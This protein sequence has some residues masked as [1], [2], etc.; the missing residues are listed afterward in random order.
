M[1]RAASSTSASGEDVQPLKWRLV[2][3]FS[4]FK[5]ALMTKKAPIYPPS[6]LNTAKDDLDDAIPSDYVSRKRQNSVLGSLKNASQ[7]VP[8]G[9]LSG[10]G[11]VSGYE[12]V[13]NWLRNEQQAMNGE[14]IQNT[15]DGSVIIKEVSPSIY[16][17]KN[18]VLPMNPMEMDD[19]IAGPLP[20]PQEQDYPLIYCDEDGNPVRPP[21]INFD[22]RERYHMLKLKKSVAATEQLRNS[23][24]YMV[25]PDETIS[26]TRPNNKVDCST[27]THNREYLNKALHFTALKK[28]LALRNRK[29]RGKDLGRRMFS[30]SFSYDPIEAK[31]PEDD[32][33]KLKGYLGGLSQPTFNEITPAPKNPSLPDQEIEPVIKLKNSLSDRTGFQDALRSGKAASVLASSNQANK[34]FDLSNIIQLKESTL[35]A[36]KPSAGPS[37]GF[38]FDLNKESLAPLLDKKTAGI[39]V[40][41]TTTS[42]I[43][44]GTEPL[45]SSDNTQSGSKVS[46]NA[47]NIGSQ[48][49]VTFISLT[50]PDED[51]EARVTKKSRSKSETTSQPFVFGNSTKSVDSNSSTVFP[52]SSL[53]KTSTSLLGTDSSAS[54]PI[55]FGSADQSSKE[56]SD[57]HTLAQPSNKAPREIEPPKFSFGAST[58]Q[59]EEKSAGKFSFGNKSSESIAKQEVPNISFGTIPVAKE[60][61]TKSPTPLFG[62]SVN[63]LETINTKS[64]PKPAFSLSNDKATESTSI[65]SGFGQ[66]NSPNGT[67]DKEKSSSL[68]FKGTE[69]TTSEDSNKVEKSTCL[70]EHNRIA[71]KG[72]SSITSAPPVS[73]TISFGDSSSP[74]FSSTNATEKSRSTPRFEPTTDDKQKSSGNASIFGPSKGTEQKETPS[75]GASDSK[76]QFLFGQATKLGQKTESLS[77]GGFKPKVTTPF[78]F[79]GSSA[80]FGATSTTST[81]ETTNES[82][83]K[84][85]FSSGAVDNGPSMQPDSGSL[86][87]GS[88][89]PALALS[90]KQSTSFAGTP[91]QASVVRPFSNS[92][93]ST[94]QPEGTS[95]NFG[96]STTVDPASIFGGGNN[97]PT[98]AFNFSVGNINNASVPAAT[99]NFGQHTA[100][101]PG[102]FSFSSKAMGSFGGSNTSPST[103][104]NMGSSSQTNLVNSSNTP[105]ASA[106]FGGFGNTSNAPSAFNGSRSVTPNALGAPNSGFN[107]SGNAMNNQP[108]NQFQQ[109]SGFGST[110]PQPSAFGQAPQNF[111]LNGGTPQPGGFGNAPGGF[112]FGNNNMNNTPFGGAPN[113]L[114]Q[115]SREATPF[116]GAVPQGDMG[117]AQGFTP[118]VANISGRKIAQM[119]QRKRF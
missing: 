107:F 54:K 64:I 106:G 36:K 50:T 96:A 12:T 88:V 62:T 89:K 59:P 2:R 30:G 78:S 84:R 103:G 41:A 77:E 90:L 97:G 13:S 104:F 32:K 39:S 34:P 112:S 21:F 19:F 1:K 44:K 108:V 63:S 92:A 46:T 8:R 35:P 73:S 47:S 75:F 14:V 91:S 60:S 83:A 27:Q 105:A 18:Q 15:E 20:P 80:T 45:F 5:D 86:F 101:K 100:P 76:P 10:Q 81:G 85:P 40:P 79:G 22:P 51:E 95:F 24:K 49:R 119:R 113:N 3:V 102:G 16:V 110:T 93:T 25:D 48:P 74:A 37:S 11:S 98:P 118:P 57:L 115:G 69:K 71:S 82:L 4:A 7:S 55:M 114:G 109:N 28:K 61:V 33:T 99:S 26:Y 87:G 29:Q 67:F 6:N 66:L 58:S 23:M 117:Q 53:F 17:P 43:N 9:S 56:P 42:T 52:G 111:Q 72:D 70:F 65:F 31:A 94:P 38:K 68:G 116:G